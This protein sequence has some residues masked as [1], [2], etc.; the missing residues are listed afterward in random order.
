MPPLKPMK[1]DQHHE[2]GDRGGH[3]RCI[4]VAQRAD[5]P[6][7]R[8]PLAD[9]ADTGDD[10]GGLPPAPHLSTVSRNGMPALL[11]MNCLVQEC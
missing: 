8:Q 5:D 6:H 4:V 3:G 2:R 1:T 7:G 11:R 9:V 10:K